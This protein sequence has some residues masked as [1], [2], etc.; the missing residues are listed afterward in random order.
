MIS[1]HKHHNKCQLLFKEIK[2][3]LK[4]NS[5]VSS[6]SLLISSRVRQRNITDVLRKY[7]KLHIKRILHKSWESLVCPFSIGSKLFCLGTKLLR[8]GFQSLSFEGIAPDTFRGKNKNRPD[9]TE[10]FDFSEVRGSLRRG[11]WAPDRPR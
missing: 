2:R 8:L 3:E 11:L 7:F 10:L 6:F 9:Y 4:K 5:L 1:Y